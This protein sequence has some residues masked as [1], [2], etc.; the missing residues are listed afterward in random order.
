MAGNMKETIAQAAKTLLLEKGIK[1]LTVKDIVDKCKITRQTF[2]Y[3]FEDILALSRWMLEHDTEQTLLNAKAF[4]SG[5]ERLRYLFVMAVNSMPYLKKGIQGVYQSELENLFAQ[6]I[7]SLFEQICDEE[8]LY[9][10]RSRF[11]VKLIIRYH[12]QAILGIMH[13]WTEADTKNLDQIVH[14]VFLLMTEGISPLK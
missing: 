13:N 8:N 1:K 9:S 5:E 14:T 11:E 3:H 10:S 4:D 7:Q 6:H 2:Y 12:S